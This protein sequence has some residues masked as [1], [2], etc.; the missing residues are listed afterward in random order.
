VRYTISHVFDIGADKFWDKLFF[1]P[2]YNEALFPGHLK[3]NL[4]RVLELERKPDGSVHRRIECAPPVELPA[5]AKKVMGESTSYVEDGYF[6]PKTQRFDVVVTPKVA[7]DKIKTQ[8]SLWIEPRGDKRVERFAAVDSSV[9][10]FG[11][12]KLLEAF[13]EKQTRA[14]YDTAAAFTNA[15]I[16]QKGL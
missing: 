10:V 9:N 6:D 14:T 15:W 16:K 8:V 3:F 13:I 4:Y 5:V 12:G 2:E 1:D 7:A 11:V